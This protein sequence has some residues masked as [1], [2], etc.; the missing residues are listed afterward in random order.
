MPHGVCYVWNPLLIHLHAWGDGLTALAYFSIPLTILYL[1]RRR[2][3][4]P[5]R[6]MLAWFAIFILACGTTHVFEVISIWSPVYWLSGLSKVITATVS[7]GVAIA[8]WHQRNDFLNLPSPE[9][10]RRLNE[11]LDALVKE[12]TADLTATNERLREEIAHRRSAEEKAASLNH[13]LHRRVSELRTLLDLLPVGIAIKNREGAAELQYN[14]TFAELFGVPTP[15]QEGPYPAPAGL[16]KGVRCFIDDEEVAYDALPLVRGARE[17]IARHDVELKVQ[18]PNGTERDLLVSVEP[19]IEAD[20][21]VRGSVGTFQDLTRRTR[22]EQDRLKFERDLHETQKLESLG[23]LAG[24]IAHDFNNLLTGILGHSSLI[25]LAPGQR[26]PETLEAL[27]QIETSAERA[28]DLCR[29][30]MAYA[31]KGRFE[32]KPINLS[33]L[34]AETGKLLD[35]SVGKVAQ[36]VYHLAEGL[37]AVIGDPTQIR[38]VLMNLVINAS[39]AVEPKQGRITITTTFIEASAEYLDSLALANELQP[40]PFLSLEVQDNGKGMDEET[41]SRIFDPFFT[42]KFTGRG[43]GLAA[44]RGIVQGHRGGIRLYSEPN[45]GT[46]FKILLPAA[47]H[48]AEQEI[49]PTVDFVPGSYH[50]Y[51]LVVDD[52]HSVRTV[53]QNALERLGFVVELATN[54]IDALARI[55]TEPQHFSLVIVDLT[56]PEMDG[57]TV[58]AELRRIAPHLPVLL[59]SGFNEQETIQRMGTRLP[60]AFLGKPFTIDGLLEKVQLCLKPSTD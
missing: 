16:F 24:G 36:L 59:M 39:E 51:I 33:Q 34:V 20:G 58:I 6:T 32:Q 60:N 15:A 26:R 56:M 37:P 28:A 9:T 55:R 31:G 45:H 17:G 44:V 46:L 27:G 13:D 3:D 38:Q 11:E 35:V 40:G 12:R 14:R 52:E 50:G 1:L 54:G 30:L 57:D 5:F 23:V 7:I 8:L 43:L 48:P 22:E 41:R 4:F 53:A 2:A 29:Q 21:Q 25:R 47:S 42:T 18:L 10:Y 19:I 49:K